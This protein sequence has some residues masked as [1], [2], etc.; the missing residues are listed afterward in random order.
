MSY[1]HIYSSQPL[2][3][4]RGNL[5]DDLDDMLGAA[6]EVTGGG[7]GKRGWN[8]DLEI[9]EDDKFQDWL[10]DVIAFLKRQDVPVDTYLDTESGKWHVYA[11]L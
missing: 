5:E 10:R 6:G 7:S 11:N 8:I 2:N 4:A 1:I 3:S 9:Y